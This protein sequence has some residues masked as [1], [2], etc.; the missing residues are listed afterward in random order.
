MAATASGHQKRLLQAGCRNPHPRRALARHQS[1]A[2][3]VGGSR[4]AKR[5]HLGGGSVDADEAKADRVRGVCCAASLAPAQGT[6]DA[7]DGGAGSCDAS[8]LRAGHGVVGGGGGRKGG[9]R[10]IAVRQR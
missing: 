5:G 8:N 1:A 9:Q 2:A 6:R 7:P 10:A 4:P 3:P